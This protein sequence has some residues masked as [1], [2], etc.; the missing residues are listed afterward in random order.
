MDEV[1]V[2]DFEPRPKPLRPKRQPA[3]NRADRL[4]VL[5]EKV[6]REV[7]N[8]NLEV[9]DQNIINSEVGIQKSGNVLSQKSDKVNVQVQSEVGKQK[10]NSRSAHRGSTT[11]RPGVKWFS[12]PCLPRLS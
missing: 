5:F 10:S 4:R 1:T 7:S 11:Q 2:E 3:D 6:Q 8:S 12:C 9:E